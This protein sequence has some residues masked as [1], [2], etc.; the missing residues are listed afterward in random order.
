LE[1]Q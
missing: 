1:A